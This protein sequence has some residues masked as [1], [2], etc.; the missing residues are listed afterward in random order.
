MALVCV[1]HL[2]YRVALQY[3]KL[4]PE[5]IRNELSHVQLSLL[6]HRKTNARYGLPS[7]VGQHA[8]KIYQMMGM[9]LTTVPFQIA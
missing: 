4:S 3:E 9:K 7:R 8:K 6:K 2:E 1:R 5:V